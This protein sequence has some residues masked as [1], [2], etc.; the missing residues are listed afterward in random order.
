M[1]VYTGPEKKKVIAIP[2]FYAFCKRRGVV[3]IAIVMVFM[4]SRSLMST[5][6]LDKGFLH[7]APAAGLLPLYYPNASR[8]KKYKTKKKNYK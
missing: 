6:L 7:K 3:G 5:L 8:I 1:I 2:W 4:C